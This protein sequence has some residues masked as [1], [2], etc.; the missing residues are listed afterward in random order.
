MVAMTGLITAKL[1]THLGVPML[2]A[3]LIVLAVGVGVGLGQGFLVAYKGLPSFIVTLAG[4]IICRG[5]ALFVAESQI[6]SITEPNFLHI[7]SGYLPP[8]V[9]YIAAII[10][11]ILYILFLFK[12]RS[13]ARKNNYEILSLKNDMLKTITVVA[14][15]AVFIV[16]MNAYSG[17]P[18]IALFFIIL[19]AVFSLV[20]TKTRFGKY[21]YAIGGNAES[22][23]VSGVS[24][25]RIILICFVIMGVLSSLAGIMLAARV[26]QTN[27]SAGTLYEMDT[28]SACIIGGISLT[29]GKG[30]I[31]NAVIGTL[32]IITL[33]NGLSLLNINTMV[34][35]IIRG[36]VFIGAVWFDIKL[37]AKR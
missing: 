11:A 13:S 15:V 33:S 22:A 26:G 31:S 28:I 16:L 24:V 8:S 36:C 30:K 17:V 18:L 3:I 5:M 37:S 34:Q 2:L 25:P 12:R 35:Y 20:L 32:L 23:K 27:N 21:V 14:G 9:G 6:I 1:I 4:M 10:F 7:G 29:G 19:T